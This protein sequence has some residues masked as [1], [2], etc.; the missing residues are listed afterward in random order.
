MALSLPIWIDRLRVVR[1]EP[2]P[3]VEGETTLR[4]V[5]TKWIPARISP[6]SAAEADNGDRPKSVAD[7]RE[8]T[9]SLY[10][11]DGTLTLVRKQDKVEVDA[12]GEVIAFEVLSCQVPRDRSGASLLQYLTLVRREEH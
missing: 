4:T 1:R 2:G 9:C 7:T 5:K 6:S 3:R 12:S 10:D 11:S 8:L